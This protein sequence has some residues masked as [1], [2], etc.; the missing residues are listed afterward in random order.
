MSKKSLMQR[1]KKSEH[2]IELSD[3]FFHKPSG[4][5]L[6]CLL[7]FGLTVWTFAPAIRADFQYFDDSALL[8]TNTHVNTG[9]G[10]QNLSWALFS[11]E[12]A[13]WCP[14]SWISHML[15]FTVFGKAP[16]G[17]HL[18]NVL[19]HVVNGVLLF[20]VLKRMTGALWRSLIVAAL[21]ALHPLRV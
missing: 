11:L 7:F 17:H 1:L 2:P 8:L 13:N 4:V 21:F 14:L 12:Y 19:L 15:D 3:S 5:F 6:V 18:T 10:W 20:L 9:V 16:W